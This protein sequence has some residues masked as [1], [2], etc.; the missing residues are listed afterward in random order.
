VLLISAVVLAFALSFVGQ[1]YLTRRGGNDVSDLI[2]EPKR[3]VSMSP[4]VTEVLFALG[5]GEKVV[6]VTTFCTYPPETK[7]IRTVGGVADTNYEAIVELEPDV[8]IVRTENEGAAARLRRLGVS[9]LT[10][11]HNSVDGI[12]DS[13]MV[14]GK[15]C[16]A[17][18]RAAEQ[19]ANL[20]ERM[21]Q[22]RDR[23]QG[24]PRPKV[25]VSIGRTAGTGKIT[26]LYVAGNDGFYSV[27]VEA[28]G[29]RIAFA[30]AA[31]SF[32][33]ISAEGVIRE[34]PDVIVDILFNLNELGM[35]AEEIE[36]DW[37]SLSG[38]SAV[39][40]GR[41]HLTGQ[42]FMLIPGPRFILIA[43]ELRRIIHP[44]VESE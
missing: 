34:N 22:I 26:D 44:E 20:R 29:G 9:V 25:L 24:L 33:T 28:A 38:V 3:I 31:S 27:L 12:L 1:W 19:V 35:S 40:K 5:L 39:R 43:E 41:V 42:D 4:S 11:D 14:I 36:E 23:V 10:V 13:F 6:G 17:E 37:K 7:D 30:E 8:V 21:R 32:P 16:G 15:R 18:R 2:E